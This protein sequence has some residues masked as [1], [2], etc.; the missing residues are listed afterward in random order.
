MRCPTLWFLD[1]GIYCVLRVQLFQSGSANRE[2]SG[3]GAG[4]RFSHGLIPH[5]FSVFVLLDQMRPA[6]FALRSFQA[7]LDQFADI[8]LSFENDEDV[9]RL[10]GLS[11]S[12]RVATC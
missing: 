4:N 2:T 7:P 11:G 6:S 10:G 9:W 1:R 12:R 5:G 3:I 8:A